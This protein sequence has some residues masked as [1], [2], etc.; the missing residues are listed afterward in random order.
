MVELSKLEIL[1]QNVK[2]MLFKLGVYITR[3]CNGIHIRIVEINT[4]VLRNL[5]YERN[6]EGCIVSHKYA[7]AGKFEKASDCSLIVGSVCNHL[8]GNSRKLG[9]VWRYRLTGI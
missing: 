7:S 1:C 8:V 4:E 9:N 2:L 5:A 3:H 6:V